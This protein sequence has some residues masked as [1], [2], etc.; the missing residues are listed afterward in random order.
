MRPEV[1]NSAVRTL[2][3]VVVSQGGRLTKP[4]WEEVLWE[5]V[6]PLLR[7]VYHMAATSSR[8][9]VRPPH[10]LVITGCLLCGWQGP[11]SD[12]PRGA[13]CDVWFFLVT[14][15]DRLAANPSEAASA[16]SSML[17]A[18]ADPRCEFKSVLCGNLA[19]LVFLSISDWELQKQPQP[20]QLFSGFR[21]SI[22]LVHAAG[23][24][25]VGCNSR[26]R[27]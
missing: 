3:L 1:R 22:K 20:L 4:A 21:A 12:A 26:Y 8:E 15:E 19:R 27:S 18:I 2:F 13:V 11:L 6:F 16:A 23:L 7:A 25:L 14:I 17:K 24:L 5:L 9:E 10:C